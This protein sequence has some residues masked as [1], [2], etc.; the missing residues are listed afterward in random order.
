MTYIKYNEKDPFNTTLIEYSNEMEA[1][2]NGAIKAS[3]YEIDL[4]IN[5]D[6]L[7]FKGRL[8]LIRDARKDLLSAFDKYKTNVHYGIVVE[9]PLEHSTI[10]D[11]Y[12]SL[13]DL[14]DEAFINV[15]EVIK[16]YFDK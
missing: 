9:S 1:L 11:W 8:T 16:Y 15:P 13:L 3:Q 4:I 10:L 7:W 2:M 14:K 5:H 12:Q 6:A